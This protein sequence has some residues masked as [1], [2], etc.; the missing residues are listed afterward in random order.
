M[1]NLLLTI[2]LLLPLT[3]LAED[4]SILF[5]IG[6]GFGASGTVTKSA[7]QMDNQFNNKFCY[8][9]PSGRMIFTA[10]RYR[11]DDV[12]LHGARWW[13]DV[14]T[15]RC[16]RDSW[17]LGVG[18]VFDTQG[19]GTDGRDDYYASWTPGLAYTWGKDK[20]FN[21][22]DNTNT[23]VRL[24]DNWQ[25]FNRVAVGYGEDDYNV[26]IAVNRYGPIFNNYERKGENF[27]TVGVGYRELENND[28]NNGTAGLTGTSG[29]G[30][31]TTTK[32]NEDGSTTTTTTTTNV[33]GS[34]TI[35]II[36]NYTNEIT[37]INN[38]PPVEPPVDGCKLPDTAA[39]RAKEIHGCL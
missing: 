33:D 25:L 3:V 37:I 26:E 39:D 19:S 31:T 30:T 11:Y 8:H 16:E 20:S 35:T 23:N 17:A 22:Q 13:H 32:V 34:T 4:Q 2:M 24:A 29:T 21:V 7:K 6:I 38:P 15:E 9:R 14:D 12:E 1:R 10:V 27:L 18:Y 28:S 5:E 36:N